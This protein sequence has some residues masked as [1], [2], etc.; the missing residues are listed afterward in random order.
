MKKSVKPL[1][2]KTDKVVYEVSGKKLNFHGVFTSNISFVGKTLKSLYVAECL[3]N[4][5]DVLDCFNQF[6]NTTYK[7]FL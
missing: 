7:F 1:L 2:K 6:M 5:C 3:K 4:I